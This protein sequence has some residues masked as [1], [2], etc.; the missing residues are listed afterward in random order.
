[1]AT[2]CSVKLDPH[3]PER[4]R[5]RFLEASKE[6]TNEL[7]SLLSTLSSN[8]AVLESECGI[9]RRRRASREKVID[10][11]GNDQ[12]IRMGLA[13]QLSSIHVSPRYGKI[14]GRIMSLHKSSNFCHKLLSGKYKS[15]YG[16]FKVTEFRKAMQNTS[17]HKDELKPMKTA[18]LVAWDRRSTQP[19]YYFRPDGSK[20]KLRLT[21]WGTEEAFDS[22]TRW[23]GWTESVLFNSQHQSAENALPYPVFI[24][25]KGRAS[26]AHLNWN[27]PHCFG[28]TGLSQTQVTDMSE[29]ARTRIASQ[30]H[31][32]MQ[33]LT[34]LVVA[35]VE[36][37]E[38]ESY[39][40]H[41]P[42]MPFLQLP[43]NDLGIA[44]SRWAIQCIC[45]AAKEE[46]PN[47]DLGPVRR[48]PYIWLCDD[49]VTCFIRM[50]QQVVSEHATKG[51]NGRLLSR[52]R[53]RRR[54]RC[55]GGPLFSEAFCS[56]QHQAAKSNFAICGFLR[57][58]GLACMKAKDYIKNNLSLFKVVLLNLVELSRLQ[59]EYLPELR[60]FED[61]CINAQVRSLGGQLLKS[62][63]YCY[64]ADNRTSGGCSN[65]REANKQTNKEATGVADIIS[66]D[67]F[68][69]LKPA[70]QQA[71]RDV[72]QWVH[73]DESLSSQKAL[74][75]M[76]KRVAKLASL[77]AGSP[78]R[79]GRLERPRQRTETLLVSKAP[80][81]PVEVVNVEADDAD[82]ADRQSAWTNISLAPAFGSASTPRIVELFAGAPVND[83]LR[84][85]T[86]QS[87]DDEVLVLTPLV[88]DAVREIS[89]AHA[90]Q[91][92]T[93]RSTS[94]A[95]E[96][97]QEEVCTAAYFHSDGTNSAANNKQKE[98]V[99][100]SCSL[101]N[102]SPGQQ[103][104]LELD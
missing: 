82:V 98:V 45:T 69:A 46:K 97:E 7:E 88:E 67:A 31:S 11:R 58:D 35:V 10:E 1:M 53:G 85:A 44:F 49:N 4:A 63:K 41:W 56:L 71:V 39:R 80:A 54:N 77:E 87:N 16:A 43:G 60:L 15:T 65:I 28:E 33:P 5:R 104:D 8:L 72:L 81:R 93:T 79:R 89:M 38:L 76:R 70:S 30:F 68:E 22:W 6:M 26:D 86:A 99:R 101:M 84:A 12:K 52:I 17:L 57:D 73:G 27:A 32:G 48:L 37:N 61:V 91:A 75:D 25:T 9:P 23:C 3:G 55:L 20:A 2:G 59:V 103:L 13:S 14:N 42:H 40:K 100:W 95:N 92:T 29:P 83:P 90:K 74:A 18:V 24:P 36:S 94:T 47:G 50:E 51:R 66:A 78:G 64:W 34:P 19:V 62:Q 21:F 102:G 96:K